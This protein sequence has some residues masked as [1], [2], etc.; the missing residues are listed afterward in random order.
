[1][2]L[3]QVRIMGDPILSKNCRPVAEVTPFISDLITDMIDTMNDAQGVGLAAP[4]VGIL[5]RVVV[6]DVGEENG[7]AEPLVLINPEIIHTEGEQTGGEGCLS[8]PGKVGDVTRPMK[9]RVKA[10]DINLEFFEV[11]GEG[12][13]ARAFCHEIDHLNGHMYTEFVN[14]PLRDSGTDG[15]DDYDEEEFEE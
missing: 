10:Q 1:M 15:D 4:Q 9:V 2:A 5:R 7:T 13:L 12:L 14:G 3:R 11:E 6:I 8:L